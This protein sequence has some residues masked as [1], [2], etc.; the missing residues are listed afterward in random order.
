[1]TFLKRLIIHPLLFA[2]FPVLALLA[3][4]IQEVAIEVVV[5]PLLL[6]IGSA[7]LLFMLLR[8]LIR[9][10]YRAGVVTTYLLL[11]FFSYGH[12]YLTIRQIPAF[13][14]VLGHHRYLS[15]AYI[16]L[17]IL[18]S[19]WI[20]RRQNDFRSVNLIMNV[21][22]IA[23]LIYPLFIIVQ[24]VRKVSETAGVTS[25]LLAEEEPLE[26]PATND[27]PDIYTIVLDTYTR[28]DSMQDFFNFNNS[29]FILALEDLGFYV[30][31]CSRC[32]YC[33]TLG[34]FAS[35][36]NM[37]FIPVLQS[38]MEARGVE[39]DLIY[40]IQHS[41]VRGQLEAI[42]YKVIG[43]DS[44]YE[45]SRLRDAD[46]YL[47]FDNQS[48][49]DQS[50]APFESML[51]RNSAGLIFLDLQLQ[52][53]RTRKNMLFVGLEDLNYANKDY[54]KRQLYTL[55]T[56]PQVISI[57]GPKW[58]FAHIL[59][60]HPP[61][62]FTPQGDIVEDPGYISGESGG[63]I[64]TEYEIKGY[65]NEVRFINTRILPIIEEILV[66]SRKKPIII[67]QGDTGGPG[68]TRTNILN[69][70]YLRGD[71]SEQLYPSISPVNTYRLIFDLYF[72]TDYG[73]L[74]DTTYLED[75]LLHAIPETSPVCVK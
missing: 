71:M 60:P 58:V 22:G 75:D 43:F 48:I 6:S 46:F 3:H 24:Q 65:T 21:I 39:Q 36:L 45:W 35:S 51:L 61:R 7:I 15:I 62:I 9:N 74:P 59:I 49:F 34:A 30:A 41:V 5:R 12:A 29:E 68:P 55:D 1:M 25:I 42:G 73:L 20:A 40:L 17:M 56:L 64:N 66:R 57:P 47:A 11:L 52:S 53:A 44:G 70:Y 69:A 19:W 26:S 13:G 23:I 4:N 27:L 63:P 67:L 16:L 54:A 18:G 14:Q 31:E 32:N 28:E 2:S 38:R 8:L 37:D 10:N 33:F 50:I 72:R